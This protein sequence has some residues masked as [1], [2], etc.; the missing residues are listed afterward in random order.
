[1]RLCASYLKAVVLPKDAA[2]NRLDD[3][4]VLHT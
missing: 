1:M 4:L 2:V 3:N